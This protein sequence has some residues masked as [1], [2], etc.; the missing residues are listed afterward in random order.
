MMFYS[1]KLNSKCQ[2]P[3]PKLKKNR[4]KFRRKSSGKLMTA[5]ICLNH[6]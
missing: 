4:I 6:V 5:R 1:M 2:T 3:L